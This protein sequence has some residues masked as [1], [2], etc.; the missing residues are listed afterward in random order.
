MLN[1]FVESIQTI[2]AKHPL[3]FLQHENAAHVEIER[4]RQIEREEERE[5]EREREREEREKASQYPQPQKKSK[6]AKSTLP[7][8]TAMF[9]RMM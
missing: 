7:G 1:L 9:C 6:H 2:A 5:R 8:N 4:E 3:Q